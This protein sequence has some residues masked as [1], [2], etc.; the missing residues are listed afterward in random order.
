MPRRGSA[1]IRPAAMLPRPEKIS[2]P[3]S[4]SANAVVRSFS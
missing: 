3:V 4:T 2:I 1:A